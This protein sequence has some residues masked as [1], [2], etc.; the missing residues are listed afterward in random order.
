MKGFTLLEIIITLGIATI[1]LGIPFFYYWGTL[2]TDMLLGITREV[3]S[4]VYESK[5]DTIAGKSLDG[6]NATSFGVHFEQGYYVKF[7]GTSYNPTASTN[8]QSDLPPGII[9]SQISLPQ[10]NIM[11]AP[12]TGNVSNYNQTLNTL[13]IYDQNTQR[14]RT[15]TLSKAGAVSYE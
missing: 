11:F 7:A 6:Q 14:I 8:E 15:L 9:F 3:I 5:T 4:K 2:R 10:G 12:L 13:V 1:L